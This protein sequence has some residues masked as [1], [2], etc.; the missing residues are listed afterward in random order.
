MSSDAAIKVD[1]L[2]K[3]YHIYKKPSARL[4]QML[5]RGRRH[6][7]REFWAL[8]DVSFEIGRGETVGIVGRN[9][10]GKST[11]LQLICGT[12]NPS[13][14]SIST[15][16]RIA[17]LLELGSGFNPEFTGRENVYLNAAILGLSRPEID[18]KLDEI[19]AFAEI[20][21]FV[22]ETV[23][24]YSSGM[25]VRLAFSVAI[26]V[27]PDILIVDEALSVGDELFQRKCFAKIDAIRSKGTTI[28]FVSHSASTIVQL[29]DRAI[30]IDEGAKLAE[31]TP[32]SIVGAYQKL[33]YA[34][35]EKQQRIRE[36]I[37]QGAL[38]LRIR[39]GDDA[40]SDSSTDDSLTTSLRFDGH[41][42]DPNLRP[43]STI[44]YESHGAYILE[45]K[46]LSDSGQRVNVLKQGETY[47]YTY[48]VKFT[49]AAKNVRFGM[50]IKTISGIELGGGTTASSVH[51]SI[52]SINSG[53]IYTIKFG[54]NCSLNA[55]TY[56]LNAGVQGEV[57]GVEV[58]LHRVIDVAMF[59]ILENHESTSTGIID[60]GCFP[61]VE[62]AEADTI[63]VETAR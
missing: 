51:K 56:F 15:N 17:A 30:L 13:S 59:R 29:C 43:S 16:G 21:D 36:E 62:L 27:D 7:Y 3:C 58:F 8:H 37:R 1:R 44:S 26:N 19:L 35:R 2:G 38:T 33:L 18:S 39:E 25:L 6:Y 23:R 22:D 60:F 4:L 10:S 63:Q 9:G 49:V 54:F 12:L 55:G 42:F 47:T 48:L 28:L 41:F 20:D 50:L 46:V 11:L 40:F 53:S 5:T 32:K 45:P 14:G 57:A 61:S 31:D 34:P 52:R 24:T